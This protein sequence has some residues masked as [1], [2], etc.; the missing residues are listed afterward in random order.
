M[1]EFLF[2]YCLDLLQ[3]RRLSPVPGRVCHWKWPEGGSRK[4]SGGLQ[5]CHRFSY[6]RAAFHAPHPSWPRSQLLCLLLWNPKLSWPRLQ[7][8]ISFISLTM[9]RN[10]HSLI[11]HQG[12]LFWWLQCFCNVLPLIRFSS[13]GKK[14]TQRYCKSILKKATLIFTWLMLCG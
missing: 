13:F 11:L 2:V 7:V 3:E 9:T 5:E 1:R 10:P 6:S 14:S 12:C 8:S 4:E